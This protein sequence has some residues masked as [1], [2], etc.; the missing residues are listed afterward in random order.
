MRKEYIPPVLE[1]APLEPECEILTASNEDYT[2]YP[3]D[4]GF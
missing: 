2:V 3:L 4:P 1:L